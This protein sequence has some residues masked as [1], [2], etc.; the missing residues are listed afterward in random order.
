MLKEKEEKY[1]MIENSEENKILFQNQDKCDKYDYLAA[2]GC[3][4]IGGIIDIFLVG[5]PKDT[6]L[7]KWTDEQVDKSV[8]IFAK[9]MGWNPREG[10]ENNIK[11]AIGFLERNFKVNYD[12]SVS[13]QVGNL[14]N[15]RPINHHMMSIAHSPDIIGLFFSILNQFTSTSSFIANGQLITISTDTFELKGN[16]FISKIFCGVVNWFAHIMSDIS[17]SSGST[18]RGSGVVM[19]FYE[20]FGFFTFY[21]NFPLFH[22][23]KTITF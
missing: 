6:T 12:Q 10:Q 1:S 8:M 11:S 18:G 4:A 17:G 23:Q 22:Y 13:S 2:V 19:P 9:H 3:G 16:N 14:F 15:M 21:L 7:G 20:L 5:S